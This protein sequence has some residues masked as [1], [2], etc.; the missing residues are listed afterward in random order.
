MLSGNVWEPCFVIDGRAAAAVS[1]LFAISLSQV[2]LRVAEVVLTAD[3]VDH[4]AARR[5]GQPSFRWESVATGMVSGAI[6][7]EES[8]PI[9][10]VMSRLDCPASGPNAAL[11]GGLNN[12][13]VAK[14]RRRYG[15][16]PTDPA[17]DYEHASFGAGD[18]RVT[19]V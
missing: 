8:P 15:G 17:S 13:S 12:E 6:E 5:R 4:A 2:L 11:V 16:R 1:S 9:A 14:P 19:S 7:F 3:E 10:I 18:F